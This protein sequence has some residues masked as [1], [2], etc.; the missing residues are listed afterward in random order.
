[1]KNLNERSLFTQNERYGFWPVLP[2]DFWAGLVHIMPKI[3]AASKA[4]IEIGS[5]P[6]C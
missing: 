5:N 4:S 6:K 1:M 2:E 3:F